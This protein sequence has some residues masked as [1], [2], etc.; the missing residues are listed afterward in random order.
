MG[1]WR[2]REVVSSYP[3]FLI[4]KDIW[5]P[6]HRK[7]KRFIWDGQRPVLT[8]FH[9]FS[10]IRSKYARVNLVKE[11]EKSLWSESQRFRQMM[12]MFES[13]TREV[14]KKKVPP[15]TEP[16]E[17]L[18]LQWLTTSH[19]DDGHLLR[20]RT[21]LQGKKRAESIATNR[22]H[23]KKM[24]Y[25]YFAIT[26]QTDA[27]HTLHT[28]RQKRGRVHSFSDLRIFGPKCEY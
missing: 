13:D 14:K 22:D 7:R 5:F 21:W 2:K 25:R 19:M 6:S 28:P 11:D 18:G 4:W 3:S 15:A 20:L 8:S 17:E 16:S 27:S 12:I 26:V 24:I 23:R 9:S 10:S 1:I